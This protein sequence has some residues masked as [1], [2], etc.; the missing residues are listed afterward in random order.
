MDDVAFIVATEHLREG[1]GIGREMVKGEDAVE[2][3]RQMVSGGAGDDGTHTN[4]IA[5]AV[6]IDDTTGY[7]IVKASSLGTVTCPPP[8]VATVIRGMHRIYRRA[9]DGEWFVLCTFAHTNGWFARA[10]FLNS[11]VDALV[12]RLLTMERSG[13]WDKFPGGRPLK[14]PSVGSCAG[15]YEVRTLG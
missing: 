13:V 7:T 1:G 9:S 12:E 4:R 11:G 2:I 15:L 8:T 3:V 14:V 5:P 10:S 6:T